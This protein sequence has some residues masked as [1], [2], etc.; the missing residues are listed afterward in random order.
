MSSDRSVRSAVSVGRGRPVDDA[1]RD[2]D[3]PARP[4]PARD[5]LA[6]RLAGAEAGQEAGQVDDARAIVGDDDRARAD[7][8]AGRAER[9]EVVRRVE[10]VGREQAARRSADEDGLDAPTG[11][12]ACRARPTTS[13]SGVPSGTSAM[14]SP[15]GV[16]T[17]TRIV[18]GLS[19][20]AGRRERL[21]AVADD[22]GHGR[23]GLDV[24]DDGR[25]VEQAAL[26]RVRR[27]LLGLAALALER[28]E[29]DGLLAQHVGALDRPDRDLDVVA[30]AE[31]VEADEA[32]LRGRADGRLEP[33]GSPRSRRPGPR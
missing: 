14:P 32:G 13:R 26:G 8:G 23:D 33:R 1:I 12:A 18:P 31:D 9:L 22:P 3:Q 20:G 19:V 11:A 15:A 25:H 17:W 6:A 5:R 10:H 27:P 29:Q 30:G 28:L 2:L 24:V 7:V 16:R 4:D 21:G